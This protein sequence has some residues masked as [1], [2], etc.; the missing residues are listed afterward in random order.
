VLPEQER[1][2]EELQ[3]IATCQKHTEESQEQERLRELQLIATCQKD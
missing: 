2:K 1:Q 3:L